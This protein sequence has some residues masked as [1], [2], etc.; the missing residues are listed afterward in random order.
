MSAIARPR[1]LLASCPESSAICITLVNMIRHAKSTE[2]IMTFFTKT[3]FSRPSTG[4]PITTIG[5]CVGLV[6][7]LAD[8]G[9]RPEEAPQW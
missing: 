7:G 6:V 4:M 9:S 1:I 5:G 3:A 8:M 2:M